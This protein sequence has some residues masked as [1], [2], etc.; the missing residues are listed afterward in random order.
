[1]E[2]DGTCAALHP[3]LD[4]RPGGRRGAARVLHRQGAV[5][6]GTREE[7]RDVQAR[8]VHFQCGGRARRARSPD[9]RSDDAGQED[10]FREDG[11]HDVPAEGRADHQVTAIEPAVGGRR[12]GTTALA[13]EDVTCAFAG[14]TVGERYTAVAHTTLAVKA[15]EFVSVVGPTGCGKSTLLNVAAGLLAPSSGRALVAGQLLI[16]INSHAG[17]MF[18]A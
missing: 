5:Q 14:K 11:R 8:R 2:C 12:T 16:G 4:D 6:D 1:R 18:Q 15:G 9:V 10:R 17:Y 7:H 13:L 3:A